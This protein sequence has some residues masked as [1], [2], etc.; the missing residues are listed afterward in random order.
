MDQRGDIVAV[1]RPCRG[2]EIAVV[3]VGRVR[4]VA[5]VQND[6]A[7]E[8]EMRQVRAAQGAIDRVQAE[9]DYLAGAVAKGA[10]IDIRHH[11]WRIAILTHHVEDDLRIPGKR[12]IELRQACRVGGSRRESE[13]EGRAS[14]M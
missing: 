4:V 3:I 10:G 5:A 6:M 8:L 9:E 1:R 11:I 13:C 2:D 14:D 12:N 7:V